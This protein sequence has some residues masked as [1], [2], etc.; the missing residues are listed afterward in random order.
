MDEGQKIVVG[1]KDRQLLLRYDQVLEGK[2]AL[3]S[4]VVSNAASA[5]ATLESSP[6][7][8]HRTPTTQPKVTA[9]ALS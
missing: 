5:D 2:E 1:N 8:A 4:T 9:L 6:Q 7:P 3:T